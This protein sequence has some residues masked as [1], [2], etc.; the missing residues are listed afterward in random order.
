MSRAKQRRWLSGLGFSVGDLIGPNVDPGWSGPTM[1]V[2]SVGPGAPVHWNTGGSAN[3]SLPALTVLQPTPR[4]G[5]L[6]RLES[7][8]YLTEY[9][10]P[11]G[12]EAPPADNNPPA[13]PPPPLEIITNRDPAPVPP[14]S[15]SPP[16]QN[17][18]PA[19]PDANAPETVPADAG[20]VPVWVWI[21]GA[22]AAVFFLSDGRR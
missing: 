7:T 5:Y 20:A 14:I 2:Y 11:A 4:N 15:S 1:R 6:Y 8:G 9:A 10:D 16:P 13:Q 12:R 3:V 22:T 19:N 18:G 21:L 17:P